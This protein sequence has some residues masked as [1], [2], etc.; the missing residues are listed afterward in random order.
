LKIRGKLFKRW[1]RI[2]LNVNLHGK[3]RIRPTIARAIESVRLVVT[4][5]PARPMIAISVRMTE[6]PPQR[7][8]ALRIII[9][10]AK[11]AKAKTADTTP[12]SVATRAVTISPSPPERKKG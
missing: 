1:D 5:L 9:I 3:T 12:W 7:S 4:M 8:R 6:R 10:K 11:Q 2:V